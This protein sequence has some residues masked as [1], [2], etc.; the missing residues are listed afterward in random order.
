MIKVN[1]IIC[2]TCGD[3]IFSRAHHD[4]R[5][6]SCKNTTIDG[7]FDVVRIN[8]DANKY[9]CPKV[10]KLK[11]SAIKKQ[12]YNDWTSREDKFG[13]IKSDKPMREIENKKEGIVVRWMRKFFKMK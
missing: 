12:L 9:S 2:P 10:F 13:L 1:A 3:T 8:W 11:I 4:Y 7:G 5:T 6:C